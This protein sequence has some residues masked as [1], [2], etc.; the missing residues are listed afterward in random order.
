MPHVASTSTL[1]S[2]VN[3]I[4]GTSDHLTSDTSTCPLSVEE[5]K[6]HLAVVDRIDRRLYIQTHAPTYSLFSGK[7][8]Q[9]RALRSHYR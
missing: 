6:N 8:G 2:Y 4:V 5:L 9:T 7:D 1:E 3:L